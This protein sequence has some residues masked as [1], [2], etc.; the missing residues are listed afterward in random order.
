MEC[1]PT[2]RLLFVGLWNFCDD[3]GCHPASA[4]TLK[5]EVFPGDNISSN[6]VQSLIQELVEQRLLRE[7][8][9]FGK[10]YW[11]VTGW[12]HQKIDK[13]TFKYPR[14]P[15]FQQPFVEE[16]GSQS[17][18]TR[19]GVEEPS[20]PERRGEE[21]RGGKPQTTSE[22]VV[23][24]QASPDQ[25]P[26]CPHQ[27]IIKL[28]GKHLP[29]L[30]QPRA[31][32]G[33]REQNLRARW[34]WVLTAK[35]AQSGEC[36]ATDAATALS[37]FDRFFAYV[38]KSEFLTGRKGKWQSNLAWLVKAENFAKVLEGQYENRQE[39]AA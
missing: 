8:E 14:P 23:R 30:P 31:W 2:A 4:K 15:E 39:A 25:L 17:P 22:E 13:P 36:Y 32:D 38:A 9:I 19:L 5:A 16:S 33:Q 21:W 27:E 34:R 7:Y 20:P 26:A 6:D 24:A 12:H 1:S 28:Y 35:E 10:P 11:C 18:I 29:D 3:G 37:F